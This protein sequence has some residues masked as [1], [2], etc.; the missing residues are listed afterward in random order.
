MRKLSWT[1]TA[2]VVVTGL[3]AANLISPVA[4]APSETSGLMGEVLPG[5]LTPWGGVSG[6]ADSNATLID[7]QGHDAVA[8]GSTQ[9]NDDITVN[10]SQGR[11]TVPPAGDNGQT[12]VRYAVG[13]GQGTFTAETNGV[14]LGLKSEDT[15]LF[16]QS[17][18]LSLV[19]PLTMTVNGQTPEEGNAQYTVNLQ[20]G[21]I[22]PLI[23][24]LA[25]NPNQAEFDEIVL[26]H[27]AEIVAYVQ[28]QTGAQLQAG[29]QDGFVQE[30]L[31]QM[32]FLKGY[33]D[34][35]LPLAFA[36]GYAFGDSLT[37]G[38]S[39]QV[40]ATDVVSDSWLG[41]FGQ[42]E[43]DNG[44]NQKMAGP[45]AISDVTLGDLLPPDTP[46]MTYSD[47]V[48]VSDPLW[49]SITPQLKLAMDNTT[50]NGIWKKT[51][52]LVRNGINTGITNLDGQSPLA[53]EGITNTISFT[54]LP[55]SSENGIWQQL[56]TMTDQKTVEWQ[57]DL[58]IV[59]GSWLLY[60]DAPKLNSLTPTGIVQEGG[61]YRTFCT[62]VTT[63]LAAAGEM[64]G[65]GGL[66]NPADVFAVAD[67]LNE[68]LAAPQV[69]PEAVAPLTLLADWIER[70][71][72]AL[73]DNDY[74]ALTDL[75]AQQAAVEAALGTLQIVLTTTCQGGN[76]AIPPAP[77]VVTAPT[78]G[79]TVDLLTEVAGS[80]EGGATVTVIRS[81]DLS[82]GGPSTA[83]AYPVC[84]VRA[85]DDG[86]WSCPVADVNRPGPGQY[87][88]LAVATDAAGNESQPTTVRVT[89]E[90]SAVAAPVITEPADEAVLTTSQP[91]IAGTAAA[92]VS[93]RVSVDLNTVCLAAV[94]ADG[95]WTCQ[96]DQPLSQG[97]HSITA[98]AVDGAIESA[99]TVIGVVVDSEVALSVDA[100][101]PARLVVTTDPGSVVAGQMKA[102]DGAAASMVTI[103]SGM[104]DTAGQFLCQ[105]SVTLSAGDQVVFGV[106]DP[107]GNIATTTV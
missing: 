50:S 62:V 17:E 54:A 23:D 51:A 5:G 6:W 59:V 75:I 55:I 92:G 79:S 69:P 10:L 41:Q 67:L 37:S 96:L 68:A 81:T 106:R 11:I 43:A 56:T 40:K 99:S 104:A 19:P 83:E 53:D 33:A 100:S 58:A 52:G 2:A 89:V 48:N 1:L 84:W 3:A 103:C 70:F 71:G 45:V 90:G 94:D 65:G 7:Q 97:S 35:S 8:A 76:D 66:P 32:T 60:F 21:R 26:G 30:A 44:F 82:G 28:D 74:G 49:G 39:A 27:Q 20:T 15:E 61:Q 31:P 25:P 107:A 80:T 101:D 42:Y 63:A 64:L 13:E 9:G 16:S 24:P 14:A 87:D 72:Q 34:F 78:D 4:A 47:S 73:A 93:V 102:T 18:V 36:F 105:P 46:G 57:D 77:P 86:S 22:T 91:T 98:V 29:L 38:Q 95:D 12:T 88:L 85:A